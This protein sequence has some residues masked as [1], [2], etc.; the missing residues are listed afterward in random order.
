MDVAIH[1]AS[2][3]SICHSLPGSSPERSV[4]T[5]DETVND[6]IGQKLLEARLIDANAL[7]RAAQQQK[8][9]GGALVSNLVKIG[10]ISEEALL[11]F[12]SHHY[13]TPSD[14]PQELRA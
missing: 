7:V 9:V 10:A 14:Q 8:N 5:R 1:A 3:P 11:E 2:D 6:D 4:S 13:N 12:L